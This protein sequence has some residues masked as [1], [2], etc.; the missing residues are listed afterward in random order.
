M[1]TRLILLLHHWRA[2]DALHK[3]QRYWAAR[4]RREKYFLLLA[5]ALLLAMS[6]DVLVW[7]ALNTRIVRADQQL[8]QLNALNLKMQVAEP[9]IVA[10]RR[11]VPTSAAL[12][13]SRVSQAVGDSAAT[14]AIVSTRIAQREERIQVWVEPPVFNDLLLWLKT[15]RDR[16]GV[17]VM[18]LDISATDT[19]GRVKVQRLELTR[20]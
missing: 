18:Q 17:M 19:S 11:Q 6:Y 12:S 8:L 7:Q 3:V 1:R 10:S 15:L 4:H 14:H 16:Y 20:R 13:P 2:G 5:A 9:A